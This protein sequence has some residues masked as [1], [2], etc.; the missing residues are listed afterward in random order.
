MTQLSTEAIE[1]M[2]FQCKRIGSHFGREDSVAIATEVLELRKIVE[3]AE[4]ALAKISDGAVLCSG[5]GECG[6]DACIAADAIA[7]IARLRDGK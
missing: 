1:N 7:E 5:P 6:E 4:S 3:V 2:L